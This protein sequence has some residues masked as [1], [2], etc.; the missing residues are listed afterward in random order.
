MLKYLF[1]CH[2]FI[3]ILFNAS[4]NNTSIGVFYNFVLVL[5]S[6]HNG[7][8]I[9]SE[10]YKSHCVVY[11]TSARSVLYCILYICQIVQGRGK[12]RIFERGRRRVGAK[13]RL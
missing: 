1:N 4:D 9:K 3:Y 12:C 10:N 8:I 6:K 11:I 13:R 7:M 2:V 5:V